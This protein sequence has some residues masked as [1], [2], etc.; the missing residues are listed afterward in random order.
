MWRPA[1]RVACCD[2]VAHFRDVAG[3]ARVA[4][5][6][7]SRAR[8]QL[9]AP[10]VR[11]ASNGGRWTRPQ[12]VGIVRAVGTLADGHQCVDV[13]MRFLLVAVAAARQRRRIFVQGYE[14]IGDHGAQSRK[15]TTFATR[16]VRTGR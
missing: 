13:Q 5:G 10:D 1:E 15:P 12:G 8:T 2:R 14:T 4:T 9:V 6:S 3:T 16:T 7:R 11:D